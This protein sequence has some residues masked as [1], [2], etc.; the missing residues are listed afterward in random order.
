MREAKIFSPVIILSWFNCHNEDDSWVSQ[1]QVERNSFNFSPLPLCSFSPIIKNIWLL[2]NKKGT[3]Q[4]RNKHDKTKA[5][6][7]D[8]NDIMGYK[9]IMSVSSRSIPIWS[10]ENFYRIFNAFYVF[11]YKAFRPVH[12]IYLVDAMLLCSPAKEGKRGR[13]YVC[14]WTWLAQVKK[15]N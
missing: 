15:G 1:S 10:G 5:C 14:L 2:G 3:R 11:N 8:Y 4:G 6:D 7:C 9:F 12:V 13:V